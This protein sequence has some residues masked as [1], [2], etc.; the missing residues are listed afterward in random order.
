MMHTNRVWCVVA[1]ATAEELADKLTQ[2]TWCCCSGFELDGYLWLNDATCED[3]GQ[4]YTVIRK[5]TETDPTYRQ[6]ES[7]TASWCSPAQLLR[8]I[9]DVHSGTA[10]IEYDDGPE[11]IAKSIA[12]LADSVGAL[13]QLTGPIVYPKLETPEEHGRCPHCA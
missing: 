13:D 5:P 4:E 11:V 12:E 1:I 7:I 2:G 9:H 3:G 8:Y 6:V 10:A